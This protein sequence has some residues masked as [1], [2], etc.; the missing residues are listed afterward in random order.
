MEITLI[1]IKRIYTLIKIPKNTIKRKYSAVTWI[2]ISDAVP[3]SLAYPRKLPAAAPEKSK[4]F[5][6]GRSRAFPWEK[7]EAHPGSGD[8]GRGKR[9]RGQVRQRLLR[10][11]SSSESHCSSPPHNDF[12]DENPCGLFFEEGHRLVHWKL[13]EKVKTRVQGFHSLNRCG[14]VVCWLL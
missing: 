8:I 1:N 4:S 5:S 3:K 7:K 11:L 6:L 12:S 13:R 9:N 10:G 2:R 14:G